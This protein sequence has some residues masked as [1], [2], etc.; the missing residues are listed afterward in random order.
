MQYSTRTVH[1]DIN[2]LARHIFDN[3]ANNIMCHFKVN[4]ADKYLYIQDPPKR[5]SF[6]II[7]W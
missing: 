5:T 6:I 4:G 7:T 3:D 1:L 2:S